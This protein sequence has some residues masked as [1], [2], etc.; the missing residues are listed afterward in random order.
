MESAQLERVTATAVKVLIA[1]TVATGV[2]S[3]LIRTEDLA[4]PHESTE[5]AVWSKAW[6]RAYLLDGWCCKHNRLLYL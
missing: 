4:L 2:L 1:R 3:A 6:F 5:A